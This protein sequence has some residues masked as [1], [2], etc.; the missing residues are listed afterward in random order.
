[1]LETNTSGQI[2]TDQRYY[3]YGKQRDTGPVGT[4]YRFT[5]QKQD[6]SGLVY[7]NAR[8]EVYPELI[9]GIRRWAS[10]SVPTRSCRIQACC[11]TT[12]GMATHGE[13]P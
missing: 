12:T 5:G 7:M 9:E 8:Y 2:V 4:D 6:A 13:I 3:A 11:S 10:S 1:M